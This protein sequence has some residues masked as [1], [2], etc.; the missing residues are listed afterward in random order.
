M[1]I[2]CSVFKRS[3]QTF[4]SLLLMIGLTAPVAAF[5]F[6]VDADGQALPLTDG[7][8]MIRHLFGFSG[9][10]LTNGAVAAGAQRH[11]VVVARAVGRH[12]LTGVGQQIEG[13]LGEAPLV[14][15]GHTFATVTDKIASIG[16]KV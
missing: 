10:A 6:D 2:M 13:D 15:R 1:K 9:T 16:V 14:G 8:L 5:D 7:L 4:A 3:R 11:D 12:G